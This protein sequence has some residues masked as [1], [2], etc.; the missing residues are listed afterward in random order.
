MSLTESPE[1]TYRKNILNTPVDELPD[2]LEELCN[3]IIPN[4]EDG[5]TEMLINGLRILKVTDDEDFDYTNFQ[6]NYYKALHK[7]IVLHHKF[8][9]EGLLIGPDETN[10]RNLIK[11]NRLFEIFHY[12]EQGIRSMWRVKKASNSLYD[13]SL[14]TDI[15]LFRFKPIDPDEIN[16]Y[17]NLILYLLA[18]LAERGW[19][20][21]V[22]QCMERIY[23]KDG[24]DT[25][26]WKPVMDIQSF[27]YS[28]TQKDINYQ[29]W[30]NLTSNPSNPKNVIKYLT[31]VKDPSFIEVDKDRKLFSFNDGIYETAVL[32]EET[33]KYQD[34]WYP[35][36]IKESESQFSSRDICPKRSACKHFDTKFNNYDEIDD[37]YNIPT[38]CF[39]SILDT[40]QFPE[41]VCR[42][43][44]ILLCGRMLHEVGDLDEWQVMPFLKGRAQSGKCMGVDT[45]IISHT[46]CLVKVQDIKVGDLLM[47]DDSKPRTVLSTTKGIG[48]LYKIKQNKGE[49]YVVN[50]EH[51]LCLKM[52]YVN[53]E[54]KNRYILGKPYAVND[55]VEI[56]VNDYIKLSKAQKKSLKGYKMPIE[57]PE[58]EIPFDPYMLGVWLG[59]GT[60]SRPDITNQDSTIIKYLI[61][62]VKQ[63]NCYLR[64]ADSPYRYRIYGH[65]KNHTIKTIFK[66]LNLFNNKHIP[67]IY[68]FNSRENR[69]KL[70]AG[71][72]DTDGHLG[73]VDNKRS[74]YDLIQKNYTLAKDIEYLVR[75]LGFY[76]KIVK[77]EKSC[78][79]KGTKRTGTYYRMSIGGNNIHEIPCLVP[80]KKA[81]VRTTP[82]DSSHTGIEVET[83]NIGDYYGF[84]LDGNHR[85]LLG[86]TTVTHNSTI[87]TRVC[88]EFFHSLDVGVLSN[89]CEKKFG[90]SALKDMFLFIAPEIKG[91]IGLEQCDFQTIISGEDTSI[92]EKFKTASSARW[93]VPGAM[94]GNEAPGY[95]DNQGSVARRMV[96]F[97]FSKKVT[98]GDT[99]LGKKL[100]K[101]IPLLIKKGNKA[102]LETINKHGSTDI[103]NILPEYFKNTQKD[104]SQQTNSLVHF[105]GSDKVKLGE[106][107]HCKQKTFI[108]YYND[109]VR[110]SSLQKCTWK[111][112]F[113]ESVFESHGIEIMSKN[114]KMNGRRVGSIWLRGVDVVGEGNETGN[115]TGN[116][117]T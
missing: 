87:L 113:Y 19:R 41:E 63:Y 88:K 39:Q 53:Q 47:G 5:M 81:I 73:N 27:V 8:A 11:F 114:D 109:H 69:L 64:Y 108:Q 49:D 1:E 94:A 107:F 15:G 50:G 16:C 91:N 61:D 115:D 52:T 51:I 34:R 3:T 106:E 18:S 95:N 32:N 78:M 45:L 79:F 23:T 17:Q 104:M 21:Q 2:M 90:L 71:I 100:L 25:H 35:H 112:D 12:W 4:P 85:F 83:L 30:F 6:H 68:K 60:S 46:G 96:V 117:S 43:M 57:F 55:V 28:L 86:D 70:L 9:D 77:C 66:E 89:N 7:V 26:S 67:D 36:I 72:L 102:Y 22:D 80:R 97:D 54:M 76:T 116:E 84:E 38:P 42:W 62:N 58:Q 82:V 33:G 14:N 99:Q 59:D 105:L 74:S 93:T 111:R 29:Q 98:K 92:A 13:S 65:T 101:E 31:E 48:Q 103:W 110:E 44:Y 37:W 56:S 20:R 75:S 24:F 10:I 40:Q